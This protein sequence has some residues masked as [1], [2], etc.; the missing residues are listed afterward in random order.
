M[1]SGFSVVGEIRIKR[2]INRKYGK[3]G[4]DKN[5]NKGVENDKCDLGFST[6]SLCVKI[7]KQISVLNYLRM[8]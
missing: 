3:F 5:K 1:L 8:V 6:A 7:N 2:A 4:A